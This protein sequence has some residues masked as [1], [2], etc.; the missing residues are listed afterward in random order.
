LMGASC[1]GDVVDEMII[2][3]Y[4][5][6]GLEAQHAYSVLDVQQVGHHKYDGYILLFFFYCLFPMPVSRVRKVS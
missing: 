3:Q 2:Q 4:H 5:S 1:G 6:V